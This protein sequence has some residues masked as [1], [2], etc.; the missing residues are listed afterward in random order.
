MVLYGKYRMQQPHA[1]NAHMTFMLAMNGG[2]KAIMTFML[3][4]NGGLKAIMLFKS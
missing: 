2:L 4:M 3:V 1:I